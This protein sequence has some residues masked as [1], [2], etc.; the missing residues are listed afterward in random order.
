MSA[1]YSVYGEELERFREAIGRGEAIELEIRDNE[2]KSWVRARVMLSPEPIDGG[3]SVSIIGLYGEIG[4]ELWYL[5]IIEE[6]PE[7]P[8]D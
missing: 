1:R 5:K 7:L 2:D 8:E 6:V 3:Q 4:Q